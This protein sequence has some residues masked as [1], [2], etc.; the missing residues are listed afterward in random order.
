MTTA[1]GKTLALLATLA[2]A[3]AISAPAA[4]AQPGVATSAWTVHGRSASAAASVNVLTLSDQRRIDNR[5]S[6]YIDPSGRLVLTAPEGLGD[7]DGSGANCTLDNA[8]PG[9]SSAQEVSCDPGYIGA[10]VGDLGRG[11]D[12]FNADP[13]LNVYVG[14]V[15]DGMRWPLAGGPGRDRLV[16]GA[17]PDLLD[18]GAGPD[19]VV[20]VGGEDFLIGGPGADNLSGGA[21]TDV[22]VGLGGS[23]K[24]NGGAARDLCRGGGG[25]D[26]AKSCETARGIP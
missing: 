17:A 7:P 24:L 1:T 20:G 25:V 18:A 26:S 5:I 9:V 19:S 14:A 3:G 21:G 4:A 8:R 15:I 12:T 13:A 2:A 22:L 6:A 16:G 11:S 23:D 10:I